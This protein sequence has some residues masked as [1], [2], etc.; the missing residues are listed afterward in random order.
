MWAKDQAIQ[1]EKFT[2]FVIAIVTLAIG[3]AISRGFKDFFRRF[4]AVRVSKKV[5]QILVSKVLR[6]PVNLFFD[7]TPI[8]RILNKFSGDLSFLD[9]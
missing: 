5:H 6:A 7:V 2:Q 9:N 4:M 8:G 3:S 1:H